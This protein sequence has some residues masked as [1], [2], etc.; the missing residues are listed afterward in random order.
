MRIPAIIHA[1]YGRVLVL[2][3]LLVNL[4]AAAGQDVPVQ[5]YIDPAQLDVP[6]PKHSHYKEPWRGFLETRSAY[7]FLQGIGINYQVPGNDRLAVRLLAETGFKTFRIEIGF[8]S[9]RW[10]QTGLSNQ[11]RMQ[12]L[13][14]LCK[15]HGIRPTL[16]L[17]AHQG[18]PCPL[19]F[20]DKILKADAPR[21]SRTVQLADTRDLV[22]GYSGINGLTNYWAAEALITGIDQQTGQCRLSKPLPKDL[23]AGKLPMATLAYLP[24]HPVGTKEFDHTAEGWVR[25]ALMVCG[26]AR[27][28]GIGE[29]DVEIWNELTFGTMFLD[30]NNYYDKEAP[31]APRGPD[32]LNRGGTCWELARRTVEAVKR[33]HTKARCIWGFSNTT[34]YHCAVAKLPPGMNGQSYHPYG[35]GTRN[36]REREPHKDRPDFNLEGYT[37][38]IDARMP[39][40]WAHTF[41]QTECL[42]RLLNPKTR[43]EQ[44]AEGTSRCYH[45]I[46][47]HGVVPG[48]CGITDVAQG[49]QLKSLCLARS[50]CLWM[51]KGVDVMHYF[52]AYDRD[53]L[54]FGILPPDLPKLAPDTSLD[55]AATPPMRAVRNLTRRLANS[56]PFEKTRPLEVEVTA[57]GPQKK[58]FEGDGKHPPLWHR[59]VVAVLP[60]QV[61][62]DKFALVAY[63]MTYDV[64]RPIEPEKYRLSIRGVRGKA[65]TELYDPHEDR[66]IPLPN[67]E[68]GGDRVDLVVPLVD[69]PRMLMFSE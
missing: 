48:E 14:R 40:G 25:Y 6:W 54:S 15:Q 3:L 36:L 69:H 52:T 63:V 12:K 31:K 60:F 7:D 56:V 57:L 47:E 27:E 46:T 26:L 59:D 51:N 5:P 17:N 66:T 49:W 45:Y 61:R 53:A 34:F 18:V 1:P 64:T 67:A 32:F 42:M 41:I 8:G 55:Q 19:K 39:E 2:A 13:L 50:L 21:G 35:T 16:L 11:E 43:L 62:P 38:P 68:R 29:F 24:L 9:V 10:D 58:I 23:K 28:A 30:I 20:F 33:E 22:V 65:A 44:H 4:G 37:P